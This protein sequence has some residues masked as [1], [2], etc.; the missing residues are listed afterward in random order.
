MKIVLASITALTLTPSA[1]ATCTDPCL[2]TYIDTRNA[3]LTLGTSKVPHTELYVW[4]NYDKYYKD[5]K[6]ICS[7]PSNT[8]SVEFKAV[9]DQGGK[10]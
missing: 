5:A 4:V 7:Q 6:R 10:P 2:Y 3:T 1:N 9:L 8:C